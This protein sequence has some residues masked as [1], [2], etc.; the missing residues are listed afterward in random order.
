MFAPAPLLPT[1]SSPRESKTEPAAPTDNFIQK[2]ST[3]STDSTPEEHAS[4]AA[5]RRLADHNDSTDFD[6]FDTYSTP[7]RMPFASRTDELRIHQFDKFDSF[8]TCFG[9][10]RA[11]AGPPNHWGRQPRIRQIRQFRHLLRPVSSVGRAAEP[12]GTATPNSTNSTFSTPA[13]PRVE[14]QQ[15]HRTTRDRN[16]GFD[17]FDSFDT[18]FSPFRTYS[19]LLANQVQRH[20][21]PMPMRPVLEKIDALPGA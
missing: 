11:S 9:P 3:N 14:R 18:S 5:S 6:T 2:H 15:G 16:P 1:P 17:K 21:T 19:R 10:C 4:I 8:D 20:R 13:P 7:C 12:P